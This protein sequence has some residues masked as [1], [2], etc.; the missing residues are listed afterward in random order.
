[1]THNHCKWTQNSWNRKKKAI[2]VIIFSGLGGSEI[3]LW[4]NVMNETAKTKQKKTDLS[5]GW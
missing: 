5:G 2:R 4:F 1:M 3:R